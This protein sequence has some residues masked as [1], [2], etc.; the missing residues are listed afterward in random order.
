[1]NVDLNHPYLR[2]VVESTRF[3]MRDFPELNRLTAGMDH[4]DRHIAWAV[5]D[6]L[7][8]WESTP[9]FI[10]VTL[11]DIIDRGWSHI[12]IRGVAASLLESLMFLH[13][14]NYL[15]YSDGGINVQT[16]NPQM[17]QATIQYMRNAY[18]QKKLRALVAQNIENE[19][20]T[21]S[22]GVHSEYIY[23]NLLGS[24]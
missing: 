10:S 16:E 14:R 18:E 24:Y 5:V 21:A 15:A 22:R 4:N 19:L 12:F 9:P 3:F 17:L 23:V 11:Q 2:M 13:M 20:S 8:D 7:S 1:M 6:T